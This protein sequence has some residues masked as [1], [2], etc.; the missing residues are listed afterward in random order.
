MTN[1]RKGAQFE[2]E[3]VAIFRKNGFE[4]MRSAGSKS[5]YDLVIWKET[6]ENKKI[7]FV[8]FVQCKVKK[9]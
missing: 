6:S 9:L 2:R 7:C 3:V 5:P 1:Y 4:A 8:V